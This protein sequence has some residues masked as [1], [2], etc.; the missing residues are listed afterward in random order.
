MQGLQLKAPPISAGPWLW[1]EGSLRPVHPSPNVATIMSGE[2]CAIYRDRP[3][4]EWTAERDA[5]DAMIAAAPVLADALREIVQ[6]ELDAIAEMQVQRIPVHTDTPAFKR[7]E[8][9]RAALNA[10]GF[11]EEATSCR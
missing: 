3:Y 7:L 1:Q 5:N 11:T 9:A 10:A 6:A 4:E 2:G 8:K